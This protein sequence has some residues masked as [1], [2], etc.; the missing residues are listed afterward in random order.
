MLELGRLR[1]AKRD[2]LRF[3]QQINRRNRGDWDGLDALVFDVG[4]FVLLSVVVV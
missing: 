1:V 2:Q 4:Q 3:A